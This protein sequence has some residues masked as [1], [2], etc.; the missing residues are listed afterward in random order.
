MIFH[1]GVCKNIY[2]YIVFYRWGLTEQL[3]DDSWSSLKYMYEWPEAGK[4]F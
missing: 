4:Q 2:D 3:R 1:N